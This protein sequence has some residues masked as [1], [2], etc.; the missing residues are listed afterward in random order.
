MAD[1][2]TFVRQLEQRLNGPARSDRVEVLNFGVSRSSILD[3]L[4]TTEDLALTF[5]PNVVIL[6]VN[7]REPVWVQ[8]DLR[9]LLARHSDLRF[10]ELRAI[11]ARH[12]L[13]HGPAAGLPVPFALLRRQLAGLG[14]PVRMP[15]YELRIR[16]R[17]ASTE[18]VRWAVTRFAERVRAAG[19]VPVIA[20]LD[21][22]ADV[23]PAYPEIVEIGSAAGVDVIDLFHLFDDADRPAL[24]IAP[25]DDH[26]N[27]AGHAMIADRLLRE[28]VARRPSL[29]SARA[30]P[31]P[32]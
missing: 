1:D 29:G 23:P 13:P 8:Q 18:A 24:R 15:E 16:L 14:V 30:A 10:D 9:K 21:V 32:Q 28:L 20:S 26:P 3:R 25:W 22:L 19:A 6:F 11:L 17:D 2:A 27:A 4:A 12:E 31:P 7:W 5:S